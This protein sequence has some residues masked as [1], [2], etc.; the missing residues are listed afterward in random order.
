MNWKTLCCTLA[1]STA[2]IFAQAPAPPDL[3]L[4][5]DRF[6]P[7]SYDQLTTEQKA[8]VDQVLSEKV[9]LAGPYNALLRNPALGKTVHDFSVQVRFHSSLPTKLN[10]LAIMMAARF[11]NSQFVW[12]AHQRAG[13]NAG[14]SQAISDAIA[15]GAHPA[16]MAPDEEIVYNFANELLTNKQV[17]DVTYKA[18][19][20]RFGEK[21]IVDL[22]SQMGYFQYVS[23]ILNVDRYPL[24]AG[25][26][27]PL[28]TR[29]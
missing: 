8:F 4:R 23:M 19:V 17:S 11:W 20:G 10:E 24:P 25:V 15:E 13:V 28:K 9:A 6:V 16:V 26:Q 5:G 21:G 3:K 12:M 27:P 29:P 18:A 7:L 14:L 22:I 1:L 2:S